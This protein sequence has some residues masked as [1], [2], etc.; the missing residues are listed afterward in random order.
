VRAEGG[1]VS[2]TLTPYQDPECK[3]MVMTRF[4][5]RLQDRVIEGTYSSRHLDAP[6]GHSGHWKVTRAKS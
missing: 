2:G 3:C 6:E 5:G 1:I 4:E